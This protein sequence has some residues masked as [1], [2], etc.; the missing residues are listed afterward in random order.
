MPGMHRIAASVLGLGLVAAVACG[1]KGGERAAVAVT[2][3]EVGTVLEVEGDVTASRA[4]QARPLAVGQRVHDDD[5]VAT[6]GGRVAIQLDKNHVVWRLGPRLTQQ[7]AQSSAWSAPMAQADVV[8]ATDEHSAAAGR[9]A[10]RE[11]ADT[12]ASAVEAKGAEKLEKNVAPPPA[13]ATTAVPA[14]TTAAPEVPAM[15]A[16]TPPPPPPPAPDPLAALDPPGAGVPGGV[17]GGDGA[18]GGGAGSGRADDDAVRE[19]GATA[20]ATAT[21]TVTADDGVATDRRGPDTDATDAEDL[22]A[23]PTLAPRVG[24]PAPPA[25]WTIGKIWTRGPLTSTVVRDQVVA[26]RAPLAACAVGVRSGAS[27]VWSFRIG[28]DGAVSGTAIKGASTT[29]VRCVAAVATGWTFAKAKQ[30]TIAKVAFTA[31]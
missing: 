10:E 4:G 19:L 20:T 14:A 23:K 25:A 5:V 11:A 3:A 12:A 16:P 9:H 7:V 31:P 27:F 1:G 22:P 17:R 26:A 28:A 18:S 15:P 24:A 21:A 30:A 13:A 29:L 6:G 8:A 2:G